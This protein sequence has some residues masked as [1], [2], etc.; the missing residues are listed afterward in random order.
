MTATRVDPYLSQVN[1]DSYRRLFA[2]IWSESMTPI[3][4]K[5]ERV[6]EILCSTYYADQMKVT[7]WPDMGQ[8]ALIR[9]FSFFFYTASGLRSSDSGNVASP[10]CVWMTTRLP[11][12]TQVGTGVRLRECSADSWNKFLNHGHRYQSPQRKWVF[13]AWGEMGIYLKT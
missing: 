6:A 1:F 4:G 11:V 2:I 3:S 7:H 10:N 5:W 9:G 12:E 13:L 8:M